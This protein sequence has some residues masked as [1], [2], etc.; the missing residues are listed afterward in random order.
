MKQNNK[1]SAIKTRKKSA[2]NRYYS[3]LLFLLT[4]LGWGSAVN[5]ADGLELD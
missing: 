2:C 1:S 4:K 5:I 3:I